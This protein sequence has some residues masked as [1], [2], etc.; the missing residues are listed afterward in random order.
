MDFSTAYQQLSPGRVGP[1]YL[2]YGTE[3]VFM[4][5]FVKKLLTCAD[6]DTV[7]KFD[8]EED[9]VEEA[10]LELQTMSLFS[11]QPIVLLENCTAM[12]S[13]GKAGAQAEALEAYLQNPI[14]QRTLV[15][16]VHAEKLDERKKLTKTAKRHIVVDCLTPKEPVALKLMQEEATAS[17]LQIE[18]A[19]IKEI[20]HRCG[21][22]SLSFNEMKKLAVFA[23]GRQ[24][25]LEDVQILVAKTLEE[26][27]FDF[28]DK[29]VHGHMG[30]AISMLSDLKHQGYEALALLSMLVRQYRM[31]WF[32]KALSQKGMSVDA[33]AKEA[34]VHPFAMRVADRQA[35]HFSLSALERIIVSAA[36]FEYD[37][38][39]GRRDANQVIELFMLLCARSTSERA[40]AQ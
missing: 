12:T 32:A 9:G 15:V 4:D 11:Q 33:I 7:A 40:R 19:A 30:S 8:F 38:K 14:N 36:Q 24:V 2:L 3:H 20:W 21:S 27:V 31:M 22:V 10:L 34:K 1:V 17:N 18:G 25:T 6:A 29:V 13:Q 39:R 23:L 28:V 16:S 5:R 26:S 35:R 37:I